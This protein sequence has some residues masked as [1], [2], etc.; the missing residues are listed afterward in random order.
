MGQC[1]IKYDDR[2][3]C[4][5]CYGK[6]IQ[7]ISRKNIN[8]FNKWNNG[9]KNK[10]FRICSKSIENYEFIKKAPLQE[11]FNCLPDEK[12][13]GDTYCINENEYCPITTLQLSEQLP[14]D[15]AKTFPNAKDIELTVDI[16]PSGFGKKFENEKGGYIKYYTGNSIDNTKYSYFYWI[17]EENGKL[18]LVEGKP[19]EGK[20]V[21]MDSEQNNYTQNSYVY[22]LEFPKRK[23][24][25]VDDR[26]ISVGLNIDQETYYHIND[27]NT[28]I[29]LPYFYDVRKIFNINGLI[30]FLNNMLIIQGLF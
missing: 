22:P 26:Y 12:K 1:C 23:E 29:N 24:C 21:C 13:C 30:Y 10:N 15:L 20:G 5:T 7:G 14:D 3:D 6:N 16:D 27:Q 25:K 8:I 11:D 2:S 9:K 17:R 4:D 19:E 28:F 18:P